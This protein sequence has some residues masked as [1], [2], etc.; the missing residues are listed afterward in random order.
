MIYININNELKKYI[1]QN[2]FPSYQ[3]NDN[4]HNLEHIKYVINRSLMFANE[5]PDINYNMVYTIASY[6]DI[7]HYIDAKNHEKISSEI[8]EQDKNL[9]RFF[10]D[11][12]I[13]IMKEAVA[14]HRASLKNEPR[15]IYGKIVSTADRSMNLNKTIKRTFT[16]RLANNPND[17]LNDVIEDARNH[18]NKKY[19]KNGYAIKKVYFKDKDFDN[20]INE[21]TKLVA[22][23]ELF[24]QRFIEIN[25]INTSEESLMF[26]LNEIKKYNEH[27]SFD[28]VVYAVYIKLDTNL[29]FEEIK[30]K[31]I[32]CIDKQKQLTLIK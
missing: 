24:K 9:K 16:Y 32:N 15:S 5:V 7:G 21:C 17:T 25:K 1:E 4:G 13:I 29:S 27:M 14:D 10:T 20:F 6:H 3:K 11:D 26:I 31:I 8:L 2:I 12:E 19:S 23:K 18:I 22:N 28:E 30:Q